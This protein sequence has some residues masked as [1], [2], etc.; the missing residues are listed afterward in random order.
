MLDKAQFIICS[1]QNYT[2]NIT[3]VVTRIRFKTARKILFPKTITVD[4]I[5]VTV[6]RIVMARY[7]VFLLC[8][9]YEYLLVKGFCHLTSDSMKI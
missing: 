3:R 1:E 7:A 9:K 4:F 2:A 8:T 5:F 6:N